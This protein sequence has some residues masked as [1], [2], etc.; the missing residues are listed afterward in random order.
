MNKYLLLLISL[1][2]LTARTESLTFQLQEE[3]SARPGIQ[4]IINADTGSIF[5]VKPFSTINEVI[6][7]LG[8]PSGVI[9]IDEFRTG[10]IYGKSCCFIF[11]KD[12]FQQFTKSEQ[13]VSSS[14]KVEEHPLFD[15]SNWVLI[16]DG[17]EINGRMKYEE[18]APDS[19]TPGSSHKISTDNF[20][21]DMNF[22]SRS[23]SPA[24]P[25]TYSLYTVDIKF[26]EPMNPAPVK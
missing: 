2:P 6:A 20:S 11:R 5:G 9:R 16:A 3:Y 13:L 21:I 23:T 18:I 22:S 26:N 8:N 17:K 15:R 19:K 24:G 14:L 25:R 7:A 1:L 10:L 12:K 4:N